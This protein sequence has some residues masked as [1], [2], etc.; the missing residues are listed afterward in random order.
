MP[1]TRGTLIKY[2]IAIVLGNC[3]YF[4]LSPHL[5]PAARNAASTFG[6]GT[7][8]DFWFCLVVYGLVELGSSFRPGDSGDRQRKP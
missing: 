4:A 1:L 3:I 2:L 8:V 7:V 6:L 5:P